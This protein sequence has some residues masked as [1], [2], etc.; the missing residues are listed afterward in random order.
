MLTALRQKGSQKSALSTLR[1]GATWLLLTGIA[2]SLLSFSPVAPGSAAGPA[3]QSSVSIFL[4][5]PGTISFASPFSSGSCTSGNFTG[6]YNGVPEIPLS[7]LTSEFYLAS[8]TGGVKVT[9][10]VTDLTSGKP[11]LTGVGYGAMNESTCSSPTVVVATTVSPT[12]NVLGSGDKVE[13]SL[14]TTF[15]GTGTPTFCSGGASATLIS[16]TS[17]L[18][19]GAAQPLLNTMLTPGSPKQTTLLGYQGVAQNFTNT[20]TATITAIVHAVV[21]NS[22]GSTVDVLSTSITLAPGAM[23]TAFLPFNHYASG[24]YSVTTFAIT[25]TDVPISTA[26]SAGITV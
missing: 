22:E 8:A 4:N 7:N 16:F 6:V 2:L 18:T 1:R 14:K 20:G 12:S 10:G 5:C 26:A 13:A 24:S 11:L 3:P 25:S 19:S 23:V 15:T 9:F 17:S 21:K